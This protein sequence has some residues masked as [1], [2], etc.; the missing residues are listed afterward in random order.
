MSEFG[1]QECVAA[2]IFA[3]VRVGGLLLFAPFFSG[4]AIAPRVKVGLAIS[5]TILLYPA[6]GPHRL[7]VS[8]VEW[9]EIVL[10]ETVLGLLFGLA[11]QFTFESAQLAGQILGVQMGYSLVSVFDPQSQ[12]DT[13]V[14]SVFHQIILL[15]IFLRLDVHHWMLRAIAA[16]FAY[17]PAGAMA[18]DLLHKTHVLQVAGGMWLA[19]VQLAAPAL[20]A[21]LLADVALGLLGKAAPQLPVLLLGLSVKSLLGLAVL[22]CGI[23]VWPRFFERHFTDAVLMGERLLHLAKG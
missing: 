6:Y 10:S 21:T 4:A 11:V 1:L 5:L 2:V 22:F 16:S 9:V 15:L 18:G 20:L 12:A 23:A 13:P 19:G 8:A 7:P 3:G 14:V 17:I